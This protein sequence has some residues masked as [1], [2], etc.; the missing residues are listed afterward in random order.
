MTTPLTPHATPLMVGIETLFDDR[1][2]AIQGVQPLAVWHANDV[3]EALLPWLGWMFN[4]VNWTGDSAENRTLIEHPFEQQQR[5][6]AWGVLREA[7]MQLYAE[8][9]KYTVALS[10]RPLQRQFVGHIPVQNAEKRLTWLPVLTDFV[11][12]G[13]YTFADQGRT[14]AEAAI[15]IAGT[16]EMPNVSPSLLSNAAQVQLAR[17]VP[18]RVTVTVEVLDYLEIPSA[19]P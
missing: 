6:G 8:G 5:L 4:P 13:T 17:L 12:D 7:A 3:D 16:E 10:E 19:Y 18:A 15:I 1:F 9:G 14:H 11:F 2:D